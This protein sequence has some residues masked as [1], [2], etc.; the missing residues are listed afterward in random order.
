MQFVHTCL[1]GKE[2]GR[3]HDR[4]NK[5]PVNLLNEALDI[6]DLPRGSGEE[7]K[8]VRQFKCQAHL[9]SGERRWGSFALWRAHMGPI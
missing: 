4:L 2:K 8:K 5:W 3:T 6:F 1:Q 7:G 9:I